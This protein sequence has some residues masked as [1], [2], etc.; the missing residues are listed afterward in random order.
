[1]VR[2]CIRTATITENTDCV[3]IWVF[4]LEELL[5]NMNEIVTDKL[6]GVMANPQC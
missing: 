2:T 3:G 6:S 4:P 5:P 1:M